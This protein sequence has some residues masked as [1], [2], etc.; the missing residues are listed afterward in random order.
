MDVTLGHF[1]EDVNP[2]V[3]WVRKGKDSS[4]SI[5]PLCLGSEDCGGGG[6][7]FGHKPGEFAQI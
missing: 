4:R 7:L 5:F 1:A 2:C 6:Q 3:A